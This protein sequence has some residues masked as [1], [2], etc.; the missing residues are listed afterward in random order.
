SLSFE[1]YVRPFNAQSFFF[2]RAAEREKAQ[3]VG[4]VSAIFF[5]VVLRGINQAVEL[6]RGYKIA[7]WWRRLVKHF[8][9]RQF[10]TVAV[11]DSA[12]QH[13]AKS[14]HVQ[15]RGPF[16]DGGQVAAITSSAFSA[17]IDITGD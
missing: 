17:L 6:G 4:Q 2:A 13:V 14:N 7:F 15:I 16:G 3:I 5:A 12:L 8:D 1:I 9:L 11:I 10:T